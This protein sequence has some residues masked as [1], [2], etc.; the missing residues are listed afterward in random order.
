MEFV[1]PRKELTKESYRH[2]VEHAYNQFFQ[3]EAFHS[4]ACSKT[5]AKDLSAG[6]FKTSTKLKAYTW[7]TNDGRVARIKKNYATTYQMPDVHEEADDVEDMEVEDDEQEL[8]LQVV[9]EPDAAEILG[10]PPEEVLRAQDQQEEEV[11]YGSSPEGEEPKVETGDFQ[12]KRD[13]IYL[14]L[15]HHRRSMATS[16]SHS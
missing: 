14:M 11:D 6:E 7:V 12:R 9:L 10:I 8:A 3:H 1:E 5:H 4:S 16:W 2:F 13:L 15:L